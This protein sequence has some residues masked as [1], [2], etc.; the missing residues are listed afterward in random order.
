MLVAVKHFFFHP[1]VKKSILLFPYFLAVGIVPVLLILYRYDVFNIQ[2]I[3]EIT[4]QTDGISRYSYFST[5]CNVIMTYLRLL[6]FPINQNFDYDYPISQGLVQFPTFLSFSAVIL[7]L[8]VAGKLFSK[9]R[10]ISFCSFFFFITLIPESSFFPI[11]DV[12]FEHRLYLPM[13]GFA[14]WLAEVINA[15]IKGTYPK[16]AVG[17]LVISLL[18]LLCYRR[19]YVWGDQFRFLKEVTF[20]SENKPRPH[21]SLGNA[22]L[23]TGKYSL[24]LKSFNHAL[25]IDGHYLKGYLGRG[26]LYN[27]IGQQDKALLDFQHVVA[28]DPYHDEGYNNAGVIYS[29]SQEA[30]KAMGMFN[31][32]LQLNPNNAQAY[33]NRGMLYSLSGEYDLAILDYTKALSLNANLSSVYVN[34]AIAYEGK[35]LYSEALADILIAKQLGYD[36]DVDDIHRLKALITKG[37]FLNTQEKNKSDDVSIYQKY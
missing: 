14:L 17:M 13:F 7:L 36:I 3:F 21:V 2:Y 8:W 15:R 25:K 10:L 11:A 19:N 5:Q 32:S 22:Y 34:R 31:K 6:F 12:I 24:A 9:H 23:N 26:A 30:G 29:M 27:A 35:E 4:K 37:L 28:I 16:I 1:W 20:K 18:S 33:N